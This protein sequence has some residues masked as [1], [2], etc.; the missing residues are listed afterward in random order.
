MFLTAIL[1]AIIATISPFWGLIFILASGGKYQERRYIFFA[2]FSGIV[3]ILSI[4]SIIDIITLSDLIV[5]VGA[6]SLLFF[7]S[8]F[9]T[10]NYIRSMIIAF[11]FSIAYSVARQWIF[12]KAF[13]ENVNQA[14]EQYKEFITSAF[15]NSAEQMSLALEITESFKEIFTTF[16]AGIWVLTVVLALY[17][18]SL[19]FSRKNIMK[20]K[21]RTIRM[22]FYL[23]YLL[24]VG[25]VLFLMPGTKNIGIN[26]LLML[27]PL[28]LIQGISILDFYWGNFFKKSKFLLFLLILSMVINYFILT[29]VALMGLLDIWF[30]FRKISIMEE[31]N[32]SN[33]S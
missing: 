12:G 32:E 29:L 6:T 20:W 14:I 1:A 30:N 10:F 11:F 18:G 26:S 13:I 33:L 5:G 28:F 7:W 23:I 27:S 21:H 22:P 16:Y 3:I 9:R 2:V 19:L 15:Q 24:I 8:L 17:F 31:M 25:L 4:V